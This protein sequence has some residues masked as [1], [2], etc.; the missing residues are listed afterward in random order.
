M[1]WSICKPNT[2]ISLG[3]IGTWSWRWLRYEEAK[4]ILSLECRNWFT[5]TYIFCIPVPFWIWSRRDAHFWVLKLLQWFLVFF[6]FIYLLFSPFFSY[7]ITEFSMQIWKET[8]KVSFWHQKARSYWFTCF[9]IQKF[10]MVGSIFGF[11]KMNDL[12]SVLFLSIHLTSFVDHAAITYQVWF[13]QKLPPAY[14]W[15]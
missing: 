8:K 5:Q 4:C 9:F 7:E 12:I 14:A 15:L 1:C 6:W 3:P 11:E 13:Y 2:N 10:C